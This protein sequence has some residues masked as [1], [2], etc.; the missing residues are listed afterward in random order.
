MNVI[1]KVR[2]YGEQSMGLNP[3]WKKHT[4]R[5]STVPRHPWHDPEGDF[6]FAL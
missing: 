1:A 3:I 4:G 6:H 2:G 5:W